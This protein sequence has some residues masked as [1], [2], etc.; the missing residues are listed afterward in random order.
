MALYLVAFPGFPYFSIPAV[1]FLNWR[2]SVVVNMA[3]W[4]QCYLDADARGRTPRIFG[5]GQLM[6][7]SSFSR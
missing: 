3:N 4:Y 2:L 7:S 6:E 5:I 1:L